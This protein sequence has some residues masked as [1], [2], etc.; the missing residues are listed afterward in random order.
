MIEFFDDQE[1]FPNILEML[2]ISFPCNFDCEILFGLPIPTPKNNRMAA[3]PN[4]LY[5]L[6]IMVKVFFDGFVFGKP[7]FIQSFEFF[8]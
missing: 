2:E 3:F 1:R 4:F 8:L 6:E 5:L 7:Y